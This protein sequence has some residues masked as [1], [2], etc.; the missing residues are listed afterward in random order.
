MSQNR[1]EAQPVI[2]V[3]GSIFWQALGNRKHHPR[4][5]ASLWQKEKQN[6]RL[7]R[8][9]RWHGTE[10]GPLALRLAL[11][12]RLGPLVLLLLLLLLQVLDLL[13]QLLYLLL[14]LFNIIVQQ[15]LVL[16][17]ADEELLSLLV[18]LLLLSHS[19]LQTVCHLDQ[20]TDLLIQVVDSLH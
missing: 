9:A 1:L 5:L 12:L 7:A 3:R 11:G 2:K 6:Q 15:L 8:L 20:T 17:M 13:L 14:Q 16:L 18:A 10:R 19:L 4:R